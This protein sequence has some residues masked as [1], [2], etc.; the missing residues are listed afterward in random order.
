MCN[1]DL[2]CFASILK[3]TSPTIVNQNSVR[4]SFCEIIYNSCTSA[5]GREK[6]ISYASILPSQKPAHLSIY[7]YTCLFTFLFY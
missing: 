4:N 3:V 7:F 1:A 2:M 5:I 6:D